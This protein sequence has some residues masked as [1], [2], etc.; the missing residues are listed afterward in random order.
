[1]HWIERDSSCH[2]YL[3]THPF[4]GGRAPTELVR[5]RHCSLSPTLCRVEV[6]SVGYH[7]TEPVRCFYGTG[8]VVASWVGI[9]APPAEVV[10]RAY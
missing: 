9:K 8:D 2:L 7:I 10:T 5:P 1:M 6:L 3:C 4:R